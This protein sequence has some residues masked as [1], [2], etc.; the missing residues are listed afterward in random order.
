MRRKNYDDFKFGELV[1]FTSH[2][3]FNDFFNTKPFLM[4]ADEGLFRPILM[5]TPSQIEREFQRDWMDVESLGSGKEYAET[6]QSSTV[7][8]RGPQGLTGKT[9][10]EKSEM[11]DGKKKTIRTE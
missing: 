8:E 5:K 3:I 2:S 7:Q 6:Y 10:T 9:I 4:E 11:K 1:P